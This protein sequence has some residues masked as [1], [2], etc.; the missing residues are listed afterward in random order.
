MAKPLAIA[1]LEAACEDKRVRNEPND[2]VTLTPKINLLR[3]RNHGHGSTRS[4]TCPPRFS[5]DVENQPESHYLWWSDRTK[6]IRM[7]NSVEYSGRYLR[8]DHTHS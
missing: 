3:W 6:S 4:A 8:P 5:F 2:S 7:F 1:S